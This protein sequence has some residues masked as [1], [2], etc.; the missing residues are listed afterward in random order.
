[1]DA[2][3]WNV[4]SIFLA[5]AAWIFPAAG[6]FRSVKR[7]DSGELLWAVASFAA[8]GVSLCMQQHFKDGAFYFDLGRMMAQVRSFT[9]ESTLS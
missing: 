7:K 5:L 1:M 3:L 2:T 6:L 8:C 9:W 4:G